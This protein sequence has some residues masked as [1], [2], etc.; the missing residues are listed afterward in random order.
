MADEI[1]R[2]VRA[3]RGGRLPAVRRL[4]VAA[5]PATR[6]A[7]SSTATSTRRSTWSPRTWP[8]WPRSAGSAGWR[9]K[10]GQYLQ[11]PAHCSGSSPSRRCTPACRRTTR[12]RSTPSSPTWTRSP[13]CSSRA[14]GMH[15][16]PRR[17]GGGGREARRRLPVRH[18][19]SRR[20]ELAGGR[21]VAVHT[22]DGE[23]I[24]CR[25]R[26]AQPRPAGRLPRPAG[27][28]RGGAAA[29]YSPSC[30]VLLAGSTRDVHPTIAHHNIH[31]GRVLATACSTS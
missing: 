4:R 15:A 23:R 17:A 22:A 11:G 19:R 14:G 9:P 8:G 31:F 16:V 1:A 7:T 29:A 12:W 20:V 13:G 10:V 27:H 26:R 21:A 24:A 2:V 28:G 5:L 18:R 25:R 6:C 3:G 30:F